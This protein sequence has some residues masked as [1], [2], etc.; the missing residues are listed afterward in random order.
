MEEI[1]NKQNRRVGMIF[2]QHFDQGKRSVIDQV[3]SS[4][5]VAIN[6][7]DRR[8]DFRHGLAD[9]CFNGPISAE[10]E[11][12]GRPVEEWIGKHS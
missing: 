6:D 3:S 12:D 11:I 1:F 7:I 5:G 10:T 2:S 4:V 9:G 8:I